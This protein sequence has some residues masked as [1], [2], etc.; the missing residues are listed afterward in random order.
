MSRKIKKVLLTIGVSLEIIVLIAP[1]LV[2][3]FD[4]PSPNE[5]AR[6]M[7]KR[8]HI[9]QG[10]VQNSG[11]S[12]NT[13]AYKG[14]APQ[15]QIVFDPL[16]PKEGELITA[17][18]NPLYFGNA[19]NRNL[20][21]TWYLKREGCDYDVGLDT[22]PETN[23]NDRNRNGI[24]D[25]QDDLNTLAKCDDDN[26]YNV[27]LND[28]M[29][30]AQRLLASDG[31][32]FRRSLG[33]ANY[34]IDNFTADPEER[35]VCQTVDGLPDPENPDY[36]AWPN[37]Y[38]P[39]IGANSDP[40]NDGFF[41]SWGGTDQINAITDL[42][43]N[44]QEIWSAMGDINNILAGC[45]PRY[46][47]AD[48][49]NN[50]VTANTWG[51]GYRDGDTYTPWSPFGFDW[52]NRD[53]TGTLVMCDNDCDGIWDDVNGDDETNF[54]D[55]GYHVDD[56]TGEAQA[57]VD[58]YPIN[59]NRYCTYS[60]S[61][62]TCSIGDGSGAL[63]T[64]IMDL[65]TNLGEAIGLDATAIQAVVAQAWR[66]TDWSPLFHCFNLQEPNSFLGCINDFGEIAQSFREAVIKL[67]AEIVGERLKQYYAAFPK[68]Y[69]HDF[70]MGGDY[71]LNTYWPAWPDFAFPACPHLF[72][73]AH[74]TTGNNGMAMMLIE[75][76]HDEGHDDS[77]QCVNFP[78]QCADLDD[79]Q[80]AYDY[81]E[82]GE[83]I[84][85][86]DHWFNYGNFANLSGDLTRLT[87]SLNIFAGL[88]PR[89]PNW[90]ELFWRTN[91]RDP[92]TADN[93]QVDAAN[94][95]GVGQQEFSW[96]YHK[97][98]K[99]GVVVEGI[100]IEATKYEEASMKV[101]WAYPKNNCN[102]PAL[103]KDEKKVW[104]K[105]YEVIIPMVHSCRTDS[106]IDTLDDIGDNNGEEEN[107]DS[108]FW[109][110][111]VTD[112]ENTPEDEH[113]ECLRR[114]FRRIGENT[115][116]FLLDLAINGGPC[117]SIRKCLYDNLVD[118]TE[119]GQSAKLDVRISYSPTNP[120]NDNS[121][122]PDE[123]DY[124]G[125]RLTLNAVATSGSDMPRD[126]DMRYD[127]EIYGTTETEIPAPDSLSWDMLNR[128]ELELK[129]MKGP[130]LGTIKFPLHLEEDYTMLKARVTVTENIKRGVA[131]EGH[132]EIVIPIFSAGK[133]IKVF[134]PEVNM[135]NAF[136]LSAQ[137]FDP[138]LTPYN[139]T[140]S[141]PICTNRSDLFNCNVVKQ[142]V[143][144]VYM[145]QPDDGA[146]QNISWKLDGQPIIPIS[147]TTDNG[148]TTCDPSVNPTC[149][150]DVSGGSSS[151]AYF[152]ILE[153]PGHKYVLS[154][155]ADMVPEEAA[156]K[157]DIQKINSIRYFTVSEPY[158]K[159][160]AGR[161]PGPPYNIPPDGNWKHLGSYI[162]PTLQVDLAT[163]LPPITE[164]YNQSEFEVY[165]GGQ[166]QLH[167][168][169]NVPIFD[170]LTWIINT[171]TMVTDQSFALA[172]G[173]GI[174][175][176]ENNSI[177]QFVA[178]E[179]PGYVYNISTNPLI[180][181]QD[182]E[183]KRFLHEYYN[184]GWDDF[185]EKTVSDT[186]AVH[187]IPDERGSALSLKSAPRKILGAV[188]THL[189]SYLMF[190]LRLI[191]TT[192]LIMFTAWLIIGI[193]PNYP[194]KNEDDY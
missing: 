37:Q 95:W 60:R 62:R 135:S 12:F 170:P 23:N 14:K 147:L 9:N 148:S 46:Y 187:I 159:I 15:V 8:Y 116:G 142:D 70:T 132:A 16:D 82:N 144:G 183:A 152:P 25:W 53:G 44:I 57:C 2:Q 155:S 119:G 64:A 130:N 45:F 69:I 176:A 106:D 141:R 134:R 73:K 146:Y 107:I 122:D 166:V 72:P 39:L 3:A 43:Q 74:F 128:N 120:I 90:Q 103:L 18:A 192:L 121:H 34:N 29:V 96:Y 97:G 22:N 172:L 115:A 30:K 163:G 33:T 171:D 174:D 189:P 158:I 133:Q 175:P 87:D 177:I 75:Y 51:Y 139:N 4:Y 55:W 24:P 85:R 68:C 151:V 50:P 137:P 94:V 124:Q 168:E 154:F 99:V 186:V 150:S 36:C 162:D 118:P 188:F 58:N 105:G 190:L 101:M 76:C 112:D 31:Y 111:G 66:E 20:Y 78:E 7:E 91:P 89:F 19:A 42:A 114:S 38:V 17:K 182:F 49:D 181:T 21:Y 54:Y 92:S 109:C 161:D 138:S 6:D 77:S 26:N 108:S 179:E 143:L 71:E 191:M 84:C 48:W 113:A 13:A 136:P 28:W 100:S 79:A 110:S 32:N 165:P 129:Q 52:L 40:D 88:N 98:D 61:G 156:E 123:P 81:V 194:E 63:P 157:D 117:F 145:E 173:I 164:D 102:V 11:E 59:Y 1:S 86:P 167:V 180:C 47:Y 67:V 184:V 126:S 56:S 41:A 185:Y 160:L 169:T 178:H 65:I 27:T 149:I 5:V 80:E 193:T 125:D 104:I 83:H 127:W 35:R 140:V 10:M 153:N 131:N 93:G